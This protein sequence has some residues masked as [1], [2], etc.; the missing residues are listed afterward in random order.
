MPNHATR[1]QHVPNQLDTTIDIVTPENISFHYEIVGPFRRLPA[2]GLDLGI[3]IAIIVLTGLLLSFLGAV[4]GESVFAIALV[5]WFVLEWFY[6]ALFETNFNGQTPG[7]RIMGIRVVST[8]GQPITG[9]QAVM[10]NIL[11]GVDMMP[12]V[13]F[14][15]LDQDVIHLIVPTF[16]VGFAAQFFSPRFQRLGD[17]V[18][19]TMVVVDERRRRRIFAIE[20]DT[21][22][23]KILESIPASFVVTR[24]LHRVLA[25]Y[26]ERRQRIALTRRREIARHVAAPLIARFGLPA[27]TNYDVL[28]C[29]LYNREEQE[30]RRA[31][32]GGSGAC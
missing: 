7:K 26:V 25:T 24:G 12:L 6:G 19:G 28:L 11:R 3:R 18:C 8:S 2:F 32:V 29:A 10:R 9:I 30:T 13:P 14:T 22:Y 1:K 21:Q 16:F 5:A 23:N 17:L 4:I 15:T 31:S 20:K 27:D